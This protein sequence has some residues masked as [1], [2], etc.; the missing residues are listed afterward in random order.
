MAALPLTVTVCATGRAAPIWYENVIVPGVA[1]A[2]AVAGGCDCAITRA[3]KKQNTSFVLTRALSAHS[4]IVIGGRGGRA[5]NVR[6]T[7]YY[8]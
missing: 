7:M 1:V 6:R 4:G 2:V 8:V 5:Y 3:D